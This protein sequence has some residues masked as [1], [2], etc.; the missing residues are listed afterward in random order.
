MHGATI[1]VKQSGMYTIEDIP[2]RNC[3][4]K[5]KARGRLHGW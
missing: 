4:P 3:E 2:Y 5:V 1:K